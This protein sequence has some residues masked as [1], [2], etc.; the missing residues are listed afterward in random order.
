MEGEEGD[1][2]LDAVPGKK[3]RLR[4]GLAIKNTL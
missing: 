3:R 2:G 1:R 4:D